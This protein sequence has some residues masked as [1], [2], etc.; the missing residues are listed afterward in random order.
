MCRRREVLAVSLGALI[1]VLG[2]TA[3][4]ASLATTVAATGGP[5]LDQ[6]ALCLT[7]QLCPTNPAFS[8]AGTAPVSG[9][10]DYD[11]STHTVDFT[12]TLTANASF[13]SETLL[14]GSTLS[15]VS[16][17]VLVAPLGSG[18]EEVVQ[19]GAATGLSSLNFSPGLAAILNVPA[20]SGLTCTVGTGS[21]QCGVSLGAGG[22]EVGPDSHGANYNAFLTFNTNVTPVPLP[23]AV[24]LMLSGL[25]GL[26][27][28][29]RKRRASTQSY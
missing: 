24:W 4:R 20:I 26:A 13:G 27:A 8:L 9:A 17:P 14:A 16:V 15:A 28:V 5:G 6:G 12:L 3:S 29:R 22:L 18:A 23:A 10:F 25:G 19:N 11:P 1:L 21:D 2:L 7:G